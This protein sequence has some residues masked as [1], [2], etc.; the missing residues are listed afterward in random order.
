MYDLELTEAYCPAQTDTEYSERTIEDVLREQA[1]TR[2]QALALRELLADGTVGREWT[3]E[4]LL[5]DAERTGRALASRHPAGSRIAIMGGNC[6]EWVL[7]QLGAALAGLTLVTVNPSFLAREVRYV[8]EQSGA[9]AVYYQPHVRGTALRPVVDEAAAGLAAS[10]YLIDIEDLAELFSGERDGALRATKPHDIVMIQYTSGTTGFPKGVLLHQHGLV[11]SNRDAFDRW[12]LAAGETVMCPFPLFHT[13]GSAV[14]VLGCL[15]HGA[16][17]LLVSL[18]DPVAVAKT[19]EHE[20]PEVV[21]GVA[22][23]IF[24]IIEAARATGTSIDCV[25]T[26]ISGGAMVPPELNRAAQATF[27]VPILIVYGQTETSPGI[28]AAWPTDKDEELTETIGQP[29]AHMEVSIRNPKD[30]S[31]CRVGEQGEICMRGY[32]MMVGYND[33]PQA[34][35]ETIDADGWL[36]TGDLGSMSARGYVKITGRVK[37]MIIRGGENLFPAEIE[38]AMLEHPAVAEAAVAG[39]PDEKWGEVVAAFLR[40]ADG[41]G[42][43][44][45]NELKAHIRERLSPQKTPQHWIWMDEYPL[46][47]SGKIQKF[48]LSKAFVAGK[49]EGREA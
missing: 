49:Y 6:P 1:A 5:E 9:C 4:R 2:P 29:L 13:A 12:E 46:T 45:A 43:P 42:K 37:E 3:F 28:T 47:G 10:D 44:T 27:G 26:V 22:T 38:A 24:A 30:N 16:T 32:N 20:K 41:V 19:I 14:C 21:G 39:V 40:C 23:M 36:H 33:N 7:V 11:Q 17:L 15:A 34:T 8:L 25:K 48:E 31:V 18:F 35:S